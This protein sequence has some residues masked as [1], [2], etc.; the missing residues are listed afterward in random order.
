MAKVLYERDGR[1]ARI[2]LNRPEV[3]NAID[4]ELPC[5]LADAVARA[6]SDA[7]AHVIVLAGAGRAFCAGYDLTAYASGDKANRYTQQMPWDPMQD[8]AAMSDNTNKFMSLF[9]SKRPVICK[10]QGFAVAGGS[11]IALC[12]DMIVMAEDAR[13]GYRLCGSGAARRRRCGSTGSVPKRPSA[14]CSPATRSP[15]SR[16]P[17]SASC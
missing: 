5:A 12:S 13:I 4:D 11:D 1:I 17:R 7:G 3:M 6:D 16:Q 9:R 10:V 2:T 14:C 15:A 8:Y